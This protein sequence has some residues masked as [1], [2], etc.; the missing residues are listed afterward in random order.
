M[1]VNSLVGLISQLSSHYREGMSNLVPYLCGARFRLT[2]PKV[3]RLI[4]LFPSSMVED[5]LQLSI[6][7]ERL[8]RRIPT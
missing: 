7:P 2:D 4:K 1:V 3:S 8:L 6:A 5:R